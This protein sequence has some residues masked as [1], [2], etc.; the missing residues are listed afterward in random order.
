[1]TEIRLEPID[2]AAHAD[3]VLDL[4]QRA[5]DYVVLEVGRA[6]D[7]AYVDEFF[8]ASPPDVPPE[9]LMHFAVMLET[10]MVGLV[11]IA[12]GYEFPDDWWLGLVL[13]DPAYRGRGIGGAAIDAV[14]TRARGRNIAMLK[15][16]VLDANPRAHK[17]WRRE[18]FVFH[19]HAPALPGSDGHDRTVLKFV[20]H[21]PPDRP[22]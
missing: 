8:T 13:M 18:G 19:R 14:K 6:P 20:F 16:A 3:D 5:A 12:E 7:T 22:F 2:R 15:L 17:F 1:M 9:G 4:A 10:A 11:C 21:T